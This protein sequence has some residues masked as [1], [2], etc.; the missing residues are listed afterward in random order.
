MRGDAV[1]KTVIRDTNSSSELKYCSAYLYYTNRHS[2]TVWVY[3][4]IVSL[5]RHI[6]VLLY[7]NYRTNFNPA[8]FLKHY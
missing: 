8:R 4:D 5:V 7:T 2:F 6:V 3:A 1:A